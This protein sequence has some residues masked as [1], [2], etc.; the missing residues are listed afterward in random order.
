MLYDVTSG[1]AWVVPDTAGG[2]P[3]ANAAQPEQP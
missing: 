2:L 3:E 1:T